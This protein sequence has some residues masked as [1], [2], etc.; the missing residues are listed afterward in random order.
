MQSANRIIINTGVL[1]AQLIIGVV[2]SLFTTRIVLDALGET[3]YGIY[4]LVAG[5]VSMLGILNSNMANT[6]MRYMAHSMGSGDKENIKKTF[7]TTIYLHFIIG[8][9]VVFLMEIGG[10]IMFEY[11]LKIPAE[12][13]FDAK[14]I[15]QFMVITTFVT[16]IS[17][18]YDAVINAHEN[19]LVLAVVE[20]FG[21]V[22][23]LAVALYL[24][25][26]QS[27]LLILYGFFMLL[28]QIL[29]RV[30]KQWYS[31]VR[32]EEC[33]IRFN[34]YID[35]VLM[36]KI[37]S[38]TGWNLFGSIGAMSVTQIRGILLNMF[39]GVNLNAAQ[40]LSSSAADQV[41]LVSVNLTRALNPQLLKS[42]GNGDRQ[43]MLKITELS[44]KFSAFLFA[45]FAVPVFFEASFLLGLWLKNVPDFTVIF[46]QILL[47]NMMLEK[48][49][50]QITEAIRAIGEIKRF[51]VTET[52]FRL[53]NVPIA[54]I[55]FRLG[56]G[57][58]SIFNIALLIS[59]V[60]FFNR[61]Y[62]G[63]KIAGMEVGHF[64]RN[65]VAKIL[66]PLLLTLIITFVIRNIF[67]EG[68]VRLLTVLSTSFIL[69]TVFF[70]LFGLNRN[71]RV[72]F[73]NIL[74]LAKKKIQIFK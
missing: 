40:G 23:K 20:I 63:H 74:I 72:Q 65:G 70:W 43:R 57:P 2:F 4:M 9:I 64:L 27:N 14:V 51:Q 7:N 6:S 19:M 35:K 8:T 59:L 55:A 28:I 58:T 68:L 54:F 16:V 13:V 5:V 12:K 33:K 39:F 44:T 24:T 18:P 67:N 71:E 62:F 3:D 34:E 66:L 30:I 53:M 38:F 15:F 21:Y 32:Y 11:L 48:F 26:G 60:I 41:N 22:L 25:I 42:E 61:L 73:D 36:K 10:W 31:K 1:Y 49:T 69:F 29:L 37:L 52:F 17:V 46:F 47:V 50:F 56:A 45:L